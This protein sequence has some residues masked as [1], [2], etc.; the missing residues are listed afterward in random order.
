ME[1]VRAATGENA[2]G[3]AVRSSVGMDVERDPTGG[4]VGA[5][6]G[7]D[8]I[9]AFVRHTIVDPPPL[10]PLFSLVQPV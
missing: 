4:L 1:V 6:V 9:G 2:A 8:S 7:K 5:R 3:A 10:T